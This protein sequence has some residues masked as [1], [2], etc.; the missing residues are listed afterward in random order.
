MVSV[1]QQAQNESLKDNLDKKTNARYSTQIFFFIYMT[2]EVYSY[3]VLKKWVKLFYSERINIKLL[4]Y[5]SFSPLLGK[6]A[7][8]V[9]IQIKFHF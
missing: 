9:P 6:E 8:F 4:P 5:T 3:H 1:I 7:K 2:L